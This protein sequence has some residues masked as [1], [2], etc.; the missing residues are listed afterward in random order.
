MTFP[1]QTR[2][3]EALGGLPAPA[4]QALRGIFDTTPDLEEVCLF[5]SRARGDHRPGSDVDLAVRFHAPTSHRKTDTTNRLVQHHSFEVDDL[6]IRRLA[7]LSAQ[8]NEESDLP[9]EFQLVDLA[10]LAPGWLQREIAAQG[11]TVWCAV[12]CATI[13]PRV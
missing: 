8:L 3:S 4:W 5:G 7:R 10:T 9:W 2:S 12:Q 11:Q 1:D 13:S 6:S